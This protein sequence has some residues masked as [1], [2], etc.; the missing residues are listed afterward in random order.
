M[1]YP[2]VDH[3][4]VLDAIRYTMATLT[5]KR[6]LLFYAGLLHSDTERPLR[7]ADLGAEVYNGG[8]VYA[9]HE[10]G[11]YRCDLVPELIELIPPELRTMVLLLT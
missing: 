7:L 6:Y 8:Y 2:V 4:D 9:V 3:E 11:W 1:T 5:N 10:R